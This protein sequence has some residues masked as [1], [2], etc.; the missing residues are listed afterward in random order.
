MSLGQII[1]V[2]RRFVLEEWGGTETVILE[3][4]KELK[5]RGYEPEILTTM[6]LS[7]RTS[8][9][10][11]SISIRRFPYSYTRLGLTAKNHK[12]LDKRGGNMFSLNMFLSALFAK[13]PKVIHLHTLGR[14]GALMR[15]VAKLR[16]VPYVVSIHGGLLDLPKKQLDDLV[17]PTKHSLNWGK[18]LDWVLPSK[19]LIEEADAVIC[20]GQAEQKKLQARYPEGN[21][22][23][24]PNGVDVDYFGSGKRQGFQEEL[25][26]RGYEVADTERYVLSVGSFYPQKNQ[27]TLIEAFAQLSPADRQRKLVLIGLVYDQD[28][29]A[30]LEALTRLL[31][32]EKDVVFLTDIS[33]DNPVLVDAYQAAEIF[34]LPSLYETFGVVVLEAWAAGKPVICGAVGGI[35]S[36]VRDRENAVFCEVENADSI[37][38]HMQILLDDTALQ[39]RITKQASNDVLDYGW[40]RI[41]SKLSDIYQSLGKK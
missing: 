14:I 40:Q 23:F 9:T 36:F 5:K 38:E 28:Y 22:H 34:V 21:I 10:I 25:K 33:F 19:R 13:D 15:L 16:K 12:L 31:G 35:P 17:A 32:I 27:A 3:T 4:S 26:R 6:A 37:R 8:E 11:D 2:P 18:L 29:F 20:V 7:K 24:L 41:T 1:N 30:S 39:T